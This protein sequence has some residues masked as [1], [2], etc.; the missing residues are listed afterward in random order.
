M[1]LTKVTYSMISNGY[2]N[3]KDYGAVGDGATDDTAAIQAA[4][5]AGLAAQQNAAGFGEN[6]G[7]TV[8][9]PKG[10]YRISDAIGIYFGLNL[11]GEQSGLVNAG[12]ALST[13]TVLLLSNTKPNGSPWTSTTVVGGN[14][15][16]KRVMFSMVDG[17]PI[18]MRNFAAITENNNDIDSVF[19]L[20]GDG[21][22]APYNGVGVTQALFSGLR[23]FSFENVF[24]GSRFVDVTIENCGIEYNRIVFQPTAT[25]FLGFGGINSV[26]TQYFANFGVVSVGV[27]T[28]FNDSTF[29]SC[30]FH[31]PPSSNLSMF[32]GGGGDIS[33][34]RFASCDFNPDA[35]STGSYFANLGTD[36][37]LQGCS[38]A[39][40]RFKTNPAVTFNYSATAGRYFRRNVFTGCVFENSNINLNIEDEF[41]VINSNVFIGTSTITTDASQD[42]II[43]GNNFGTA[44][45]NPP[46]VLNSVPSG[47]SI[48]GN[49]FASAVTS[50]PVNGTATRVKMQNNVYIA[51]V[52]Q[53]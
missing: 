13:G 34:L 14:V 44:S 7:T 20:S 36:L 33:S 53:P 26:T 9:F 19:L 17:G 23:V 48:S 30:I 45:V 32:S 4:V 24:R 37:L 3:V 40:C 51:D 25:G 31:L 10:K 6:N 18:Q 1:S 49:L 8:F 43:N 21:F 47:L 22:P 46:I 2:I 52:L 16:N 35:G 28:S 27:G 39:S 5:A 50:I 29:S 12:N 11:L 41:N 42:L 15:I 38:F